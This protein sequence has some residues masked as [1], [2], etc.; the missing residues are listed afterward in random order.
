MNLEDAHDRAKISGAE[1][2]LKKIREGLDDIELD[3]LAPLERHQVKAVQQ[4]V[5]QISQRL[6]RV[7]Q[8][9]DAKLA[10]KSTTP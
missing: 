2:Q 8:M 1:Q 9:V 10:G 3:D 4:V 7:S 6:R 5:R